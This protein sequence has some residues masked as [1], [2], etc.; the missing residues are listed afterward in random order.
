MT[1]R[2]PPDA[3]VPLLQ[4]LF[5]DLSQEILDEQGT[6]D[7]FIGDRIM[8]FW[9]APLPVEGHER[10]AALAALGMR[11]A[12]SGFIEGRDDLQMPMEIGIGLHV[13]EAAVGNIGSAQRF[14]YSVIGEPVNVAA[15]IESSCRPVGFDILA[16]QQLADA[17]PD[18]AW[19]PAGW[20][21]MRGVGRPVPLCVV[22]GDEALARDPAYVS[23]RAAH[24]ALLDALAAEQDATSQLQICRSLGVGIC[25]GLGR[26]Y[27][28]I[29]Q[30]RADF[31]WPQE[32]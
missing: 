12:M 25:A 27:D 14:N 23:L 13:G 6:I 3:L 26:F 9:N 29:P 15:R 21:T 17:A 4:A 2:T 1:E 24:D 28:Q 10:H 22:I 5:T 18:L 30:R 16:S 8:A 7:K 11:R 19:L 20:L 31:L 32:A